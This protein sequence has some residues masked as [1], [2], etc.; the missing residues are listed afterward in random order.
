MN[1]D[2][3]RQR[4]ATGSVPAQAVLGI[5]LLLGEGVPQDYAEAYRWLSA[6]AEHGAPRA[7][8]YLGL[9]YERGNHVPASTSLAR[10]LYEQAAR[11][12]EFLACVFLGRLLAAEG[13]SAT[14]A[15]RWYKA[16]VAQ[17]GSVSDC[18]ELAEARAYVA[19]HG[20]AS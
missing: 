8:L 13:N 7:V 16:A 14:E 10:A 12:G 15:L 18:P 6:A 2:T 11:G 3:L 20:A 5:A 17:A 4:A 1:A 19:E 9:M